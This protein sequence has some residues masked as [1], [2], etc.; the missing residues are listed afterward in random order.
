MQ[1]NNQDSAVEVLTASQIASRTFR[2]GNVVKTTYHDEKM[3]VL[4]LSGS[5][6]V[7]AWFGKDGDFHQEIWD[8][9]ELELV[10]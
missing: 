10:N 1:N 5:R 8:Y 6:I 2:I 7:C 4:E 9:E 3:T